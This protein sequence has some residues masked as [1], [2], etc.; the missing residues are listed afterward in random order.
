MNKILNGYCSVI[1]KIL[2]GIA[3]L[4]I[5]SISIFGLYEYE[6]PDKLIINK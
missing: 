5:G 1:S 4:S 6:V 3:I 2:M